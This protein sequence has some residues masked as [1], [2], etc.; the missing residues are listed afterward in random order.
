MAETRP[1]RRRSKGLRAAF[2]LLALTFSACGPRLGDGDAGGGIDGGGIDGGRPD[3]GRDEVD[4][5]DPDA[6][7]PADLD[8]G[9]D[10]DAAVAPD[11]SGSEEPD[12]GSAAARP[13]VILMI[14]DGMGRGQIEAA[15]AFAHGSSDALAMQRLPHRGELT[16]GGPSGITDSAASATA[17]ATGVYT[18]NGRVALD[19]ERRPLE[20]LVELARSRGMGSGIVST[21]SIPHA[22]PAAFS[23]HN[24]TRH[25]YVGIAADQARTVQPDVM[26]GGGARF[27]MPSGPGSARR[28]EG[29]FEALEAARYAIVHDRDQLAAATATRVERLFGAFAPEHMTYVRERSPETR[30]P[31]LSEMTLAALRV[32]DARPEGFFLMVEGA[33]IDMASHGNDLANT[34]AETIAFDETVTAVIEWAAGR[35]DVTLIVTAD[36]ECGGLEVVTQR[37]AGELPAVRWRWGNHTNA[38]VDVFASGPGTEV[39]DGALRDHRWV[40]A[41]AR[42]RIVGEALSPP[43]RVLVPDGHLSDLRHIVSMQAVA[44]GFGESINQLDVLRLDADEHGLFVG[45]EGLFEWGRNA[46]VLWLDVDHGAGTGLANLAGTLSDDDGAADALLTRSNVTAPSLGNFGA[47]FAVVSLGGADPHLDELSPAAGLRGLRPPFG[48]PAALGW[49]PA[50]LNFGEGVRTRGVAASPREGDGFEVFVPWDRLY[51]ELAGR[52]PTRAT[53]A[54]AAVMVNSDGG[55]TS[56]QALPPF[57]AGTTNPGRARTPLPG[58]AVF[59]VDA[60]GDGVA[61]GDATPLVIAP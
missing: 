23:A 36:H 58:Y 55:F 54:V 9:R 28:D 27:F 19:R 33:R 7:E 2:A 6:G 15:S 18:Y 31:T 24:V 11:A 41:V 59:Q 39:F 22:T 29:L 30:E 38:R 32:L 48:R 43:P 53:V 52:V 3:G 16:T 46:I 25:D 20:T 17:M 12:G 51:P 50:A 45:V 61:D 42:A 44:S 35:D 57:A 37:P 4:T 8:A 1:K 26:L 40:H 14:G 21:A 34:V 10:A 60:D 5:G 56:N 49:H 47:D 13:I